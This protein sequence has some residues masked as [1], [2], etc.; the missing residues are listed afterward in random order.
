MNRKL[1]LAMS[2]GA[3]S[4]LAGMV[5][6]GNKRWDHDTLIAV[7]DLNAG[8]PAPNPAMFV[9]ELPT[10]LPN[11]VRR[12]FDLALNPDPSSVQMTVLRQKGEIR[13]G[14]IDSGWH[15]LTASQYFTLPR[16]G[17]VWDAR[18]TLC[19]GVVVRV[20]YGYCQGGGRMQVSVD[21]CI[22]VV[23]SHDRTKLASGALHRY[24][25]EAPWF[26][27]VLRSAVSWQP[28]D[29][30]TA[31]A[32]LTDGDTSVWLDFHFGSRGEIVSASTPGRYR[33]V[34][35]I[36]VLTPWKCEYSDYRCVDG[37]LIPMSGEAAWRLPH[38]TLPYCRIR[39]ER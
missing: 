5:I 23:D 13:L 19:P 30:R 22:P 36:A 7:D 6:N 8:V 34:D 10:N 39:I 2:V 24:L 4:G 1:T 16:P 26:P 18:V 29:D 15:P 11:V 9:S 3:L 37:E 38:G 25:A 35:G 28:I 33:D 31:R 20:R 14:G 21:G 17:F 32:T 27:S 12:Y